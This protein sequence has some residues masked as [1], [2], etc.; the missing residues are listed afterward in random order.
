MDIV[1]KLFYGNIIV[2]GGSDGDNVVVIFDIVV[3]NGFI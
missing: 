1:E 2:V 3:R